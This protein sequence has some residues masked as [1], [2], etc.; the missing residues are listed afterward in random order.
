MCLPTSTFSFSVVKDGNILNGMNL[1]GQDSSTDGDL[2]KTA[3]GS[4]KQILCEK[5]VSTYVQYVCVSCT[6]Y[7]RAFVQLMY[8]CPVQCVYVFLYNKCTCVL[9]SVCMCFCTIIVHVSCT[10]CVCVFVQ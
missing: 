1:G 5:Q 9:Y 4:M 7:V 10:V 3:M 6:E 8:M 2:Q